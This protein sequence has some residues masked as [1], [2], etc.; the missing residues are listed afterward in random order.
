MA[1]IETDDGR[2]ITMPVS[3]LPAGARAGHVL[4]VRGERQGAGVSG[5]TIEVD[6]QATRDALAK[7]AEQVKKGQ[8][9][10]NDPGGD[11]KF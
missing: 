1:S 9:N 8:R 5:L 10:P 6:E 7:S 4:R 3:A 11:L 2:L